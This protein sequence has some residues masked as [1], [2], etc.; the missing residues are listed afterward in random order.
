MNMSGYDFCFYKIV[1]IL[2]TQLAANLLWLIKVYVVL[3]RFSNDFYER[4]ADRGD[5]PLRSVALLP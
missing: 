5:K 1:S 2:P 4:Y 3:R